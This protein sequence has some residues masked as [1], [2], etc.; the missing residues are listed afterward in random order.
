M[1]GKKELR[2]WLA[3]AE[4]D[5]IY[6]N[7]DYGR[8]VSLERVVNQSIAS[9]ELKDLGAVRFKGNCGLESFLPGLLA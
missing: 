4:D 3:E 9:C 8:F 2:T 5:V 1:D 7:K 6:R